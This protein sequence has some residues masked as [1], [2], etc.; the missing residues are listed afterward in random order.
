[1]AGE[2][3]AWAGLGALDGPEKGAE[4]AKTAPNPAFL[5]GKPGKACGL[6]AG[7]I[8]HE[9]GLEGRSHRPRLQK[10]VFVFSRMHSKSSR[11]I[12]LILRR[13][14]G[15]CAMS[16][17]SQ[18]YTTPREAGE[19]ERTAENARRIIWNTFDAGRAGR[20]AGEAPGPGPKPVR[21]PLPGPEVSDSIPSLQDCFLL[22][23]LPC[24][25]DARGRSGPRPALSRAGHEKDSVVAVGS[26]VTVPP[27]GRTP[28]L[29]PGPPTHDPSATAATDPKRARDRRNGRETREKPLQRVL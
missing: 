28:L 25:P 22:S 10:Y 19:S 29:P 14:L 23:L 16:R 21:S 9:T 5:S 11:R 6:Q 27:A 13:V 7:L 12:F 17:Y 8:G 1:M 24:S 2:W 3:H 15:L 20:P 18:Y 4:E 26:R